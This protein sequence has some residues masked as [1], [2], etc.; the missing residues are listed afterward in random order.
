MTPQSHIPATGQTPQRGWRRLIKRAFDITLSGLALMGFLPLMLLVAALVRFRLGSP[1]LFRQN[2]PGF[3]GRIFELLKFRTMTDKRDSEGRLLPD[4]DRLTEFGL[5]LRSTSLDELPQLLNV[6]RGDL[7]LVGPRPLLVQYLARYTPEQARRHDV[8]PGITGWTQVNGRNALPWEE[9]FAM[10]VWYVDHWTLWL[11]AKIVFKT[12]FEVLSRRG[13]NDGESCTA[14][15][16]LGAD[17]RPSR[18]AMGEAED[19]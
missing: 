3:Q 7:S 16:F 6:L 8:L 9:K 10:D 5:L 4:E 11:D 12:L 1:V 19:V 18:P 17:H 2:R 13:I 14:K 15:E